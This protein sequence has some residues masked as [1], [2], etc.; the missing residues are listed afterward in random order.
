MVLAII[1]LGLSLFS[2]ARSIAQR[3]DPISCP[4]ACWAIHPKEAH[5]PSIGSMGIISSVGPSIWQLF[6][7]SIAMIFPSL[8]LAAV[9]A[10]SQICPLFISPSPKNTYL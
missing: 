9:M 4:L 7:S 10:A 1:R 6:L 8:Y 3:R 5:L 2:L